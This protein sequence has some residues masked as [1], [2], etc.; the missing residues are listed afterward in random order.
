MAKLK[1]RP[2]QGNVRAFIDSLDDPDRR[3]DCLLLV[4]LMQSATGAEPELWGSD[5]VGFGRYRYRYRSGREGE[6]FV[7]G[8]SPRKRQLSIYVM[9]GFEGQDSVLARLGKHS[10]GKCCLYLK[11]LANI[12]CSA[13]RELI[14]HSVAALR[15]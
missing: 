5:L 8:F 4:E 13:L 10:T 6:W 2:G 14:H 3:R 12:D 11:G 7:T 1:T 15:S 9:S